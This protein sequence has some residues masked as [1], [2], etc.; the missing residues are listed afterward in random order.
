MSSSGV[1][2]LAGASATPSRVATPARHVAGA[3]LPF[4]VAVVLRLAFI[5][6]ND[7]DGGDWVSRTLWAREFVEGRTSLWARTPW[8][9]G[10]YLLPALPMLL[11]GDAYWSVRITS[12]LFAS[13]AIPLIHA[14]GRRV[15]GAFAGSVAAWI[16]ALLPHHIY[17]S[18]NGAMTEGAFLVFFLG[19]MLAG[20]IWAEQPRRS[21]WLVITGLCVLGAELFRFDG[22]FVGAGIGV[23]ALFTRDDGVLAIR[24]ARTL[25]A[26]AVFAAIA[27]VYPVAL[28]WSWRTNFGDAFYMARLAEENALQF[29]ADGAHPRWPRWLYVGYSVLFWPILAPAFALSPVVWATAL[30]G[31]WLARRKIQTRFVLLPIAVLTAFYVRGALANTLLNQLR[32]ILTMAVPLLAFVAIPFQTLSPSRRRT[33][34][35]ACV[36]GALTTQAIALDA[37]WN[38]RGVIS[39][40]LG[41]FALVRPDQHTARSVMRWLDQNAARGE[42]VVFTPHAGS[43]WLTLT[44]GRERPDISLLDVYRTPNIVYDSSGMVGALRD[45]VA[46]AR[47]VVTSGARSVQGLQDALVSELVTPAPSGGRGVAQWQGL[48]MRLRV[49]FGALRVFEVL[50]DERVMSNQE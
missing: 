45:S 30:W 39:R 40:Q 19:A 6:V 34:V 21:R 26:I 41:R 25:G 35:A 50:R 43:P 38:D 23:L 15:G 14:L 17:V 16:L 12:A 4:A 29:F 37:A 18:G 28:L 48:Q 10:N 3:A 42:R 2:P 1:P 47:W 27:L 13:L 33:L 31:V 9:E 7:I 5:A 36:V 8:P 49:D 22:V 46:A 11:G 20:S 32:Y 24:R 44:V